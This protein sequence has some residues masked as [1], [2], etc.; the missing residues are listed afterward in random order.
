MNLPESINPPEATIQE[1][2]PHTTRLPRLQVAELPWMRSLIF[3]LTIIFCI[4]SAALFL[5]RNKRRPADWI[6]INALN[7]RQNVK[8]PDGSKVLLQK[9][10]SITYR[11][12]Y[13]KVHRTVQLK[14][15]AYF[16]VQ[17]NASMPFSVRGTNE[18]H[19]DTS[20]SF[21]IRSNDSVE[22][23]IVSS[24]HVRIESKAHKG[25][26][27]LV[28]SGQKAEVIGGKIVQSAIIQENPHEWNHEQLIFNKTPLKQVA[29]D[30]R[31]Y[32]GVPVNFALDVDPDTIFVTA[33][34]DNDPLAVILQ[35]IGSITHLLV[36]QEGN[37]VQIT[38]PVKL[39]KEVKPVVVSVKANPP[40]NP[41]PKPVKKKK[42]SWIRRLFS[43]KPAK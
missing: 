12:D 11:S 7:A 13:G 31:Q 2:S 15:E 1:S 19:T 30:I 24:G 17:Y 14:G 5:G 9:G 6:Y 21:F 32:Y 37:M 40:V 36:K 20:T 29:A 39:N 26:S 4:G 25:E 43:K 42:K 10:S 41:E 35:R 8:L 38:K 34:F 18:I 3:A 16:E 27:V 23:V 28:N 33:E 22:Q